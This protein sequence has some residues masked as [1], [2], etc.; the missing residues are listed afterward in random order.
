MVKAPHHSGDY[1]VKARQV[2][3]AAN[4]DPLA[5]CW[6]D[7]L[8]LDEHPS[9]PDGTRPKWTAG[10]TIMGAARSRPWLNVRQA[11]PPGAWLAPDASV[12]NYADNGNTRQG[13]TKAW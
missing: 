9:H 2:R 7:G 10:H 13:T 3:N 6:R 4:A 12:C 5:I 11:P 1:H 8:T